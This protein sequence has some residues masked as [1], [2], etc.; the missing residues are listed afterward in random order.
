VVENQSCALA[1]WI[2]S[3]LATMIGTKPQ[4]ARVGH[5]V[6]RGLFILDRERNLRL[7]PDVAF[8]SAARWPFNRPLSHDD[9]EVV[10][11]LAVEVVSPFHLASRLA[12][13]RCQ[14]FRYGVEEVWVVYPEDRIVE[15]HDP[16][17]SRVFTHEQRLTSR[18]LPGIE[19]DLSAL[20]PVVDEA[21]EA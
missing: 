12:R 6:C 4:A 8:V 1:G 17:G 2:A 21:A 19:L 18:L 15:V 16:A 10:P 11:N 20:L 14:Y 9:W 13:R 7:C 3:H 5:A